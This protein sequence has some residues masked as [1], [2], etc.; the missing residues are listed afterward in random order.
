ML[1]SR[2]GAAVCAQEF[3]AT[4]LCLPACSCRAMLACSC[5]RQMLQFLWED[6]NQ[7]QYDVEHEAEEDK[8]EPA[9]TACAEATDWE[10]DF[11]S[12]FR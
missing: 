10:D 11:A 3:R 4:A 12:L 2:A 7:E 1:S 5:L 9:L 6:E 8:E